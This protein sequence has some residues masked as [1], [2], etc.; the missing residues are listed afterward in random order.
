MPPDV[1]SDSREIDEKHYIPIL[2][3]RA[4]EY[5]SLEVLTDVQK[6]AL[7][8]LIELMPIPWDV[9]NDR[10]TTNGDEHIANAERSLLRAWGTERPL[11]IDLLWL[12]PEARTLEGQHHPMTF[13]FQR[14]AAAGLKVIPVVGLD[15]DAEYRQAVR[16]GN[17]E[18]GVG[19]RLTSADLARAD[20]A[21]AVRALLA[22]V[23][24]EPQDIDVVID[25]KE[26]NPAAVDFNVIGAI[27]VLAAVPDI[28][29]WRS[30]ILAGSAFPQNL[31]EM[32]PAS[33]NRLQRTEWTVWSTLRR[34]GLARTPAF[35]DYAI[36]HPDPPPALDPKLLRVSAQLR[37]TT[38]EEWLVFKER[39]I[40]DFGN[41]QFIRICERLVNMEE[42]RGAD[43]SWGDGYIAQRANGT[44]SRPGNPRMWRKVGTNHHLA[45]VVNQIANLDP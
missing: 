27:G 4:A 1:L 45:T 22:D 20:T 35:S 17:G 40:R 7:T 13:M 28:D 37:Y 11:L 5:D 42:Y 43:F 14:A 16:D 39:N 41:D 36:A 38:D 26:L 9:E 18:Y 15:R 25:L 3:G 21:D 33:E 31:S 44:D 24:A 6:A 32:Q 10:A 30:L 34:R 29:S 8:P 2:K 12:G 19:L 23:Q